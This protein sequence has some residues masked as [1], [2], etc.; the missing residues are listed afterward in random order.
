MLGSAMNESPKQSALSV[1]HLM[2][3]S[4]GRGQPLAYY[5][6]RSREMSKLI[7]NK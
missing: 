5:S 3:K 7:I 1:S 4:Q 6:N 2:K